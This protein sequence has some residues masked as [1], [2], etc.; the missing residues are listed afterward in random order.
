MLV[1]DGADGLEVYLTRRS[2][3]SSFMPGAYVFPG[4]AV[5]P[6]DGSEAARALL[7]GEP[8]FPETHDHRDPRNV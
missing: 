6:A 5:D 7:F 1:R 8:A 2:E 3:R 4:G